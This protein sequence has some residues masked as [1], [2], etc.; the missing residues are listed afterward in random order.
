[1]EIETVR[2]LLKIHF[3]SVLTWM[4]YFLSTHEEA[5]QKIR[6]ELEEM[7]GDEDITP[8]MSAKLVSV[9]NDCY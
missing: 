9:H 5:Q 7:L 3:I 6:E 2:V 1:M 4:F 8:A